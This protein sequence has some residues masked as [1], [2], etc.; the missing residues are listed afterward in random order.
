MKAILFTAIGWVFV[1]L[2]ALGAVLPV[3]PT[4][5]F[6]LLAAWAFATGNPRLARWLEDHPRFGPLLAD[7][8]THRIIP[9]YA[10]VAAVSM[11]AASLT[12][13]VM[14]STIAPWAVAAAAACMALGAAFVLCCPHAAPGD[15]RAGD[16]RE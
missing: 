5:P 16:V 7:W 13:M 8:R 14:F 2:G 12:W 6:L 1:G 11:M 3:L 9:L 15:V 10:K 4:T